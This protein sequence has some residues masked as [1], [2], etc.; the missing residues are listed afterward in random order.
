MAT[1]SGRSLKLGLSYMAGTLNLQ[2]RYR[3]PRI[4]HHPDCQPY[5]KSD[6]RKDQDAPQRE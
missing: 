6:Q 5:L 3:Q 2:R 4:D 1:Q